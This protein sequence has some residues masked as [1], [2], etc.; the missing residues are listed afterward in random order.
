M[1]KSIQSKFQK[2]GKQEP[3]QDARVEIPTVPNPSD[4]DLVDEQPVEVKFRSEV[5]Q[6]IVGSGQ[7]VGRVRDHNEDS[8]LTLTMLTANNGEYLPIGLFIVADG[9]GG[10]KLGEVASNLAIR[11]V[12]RQILHKVM[13]SMM[14]VEPSPP[15]EGLQ[16]IVSESVLEAHHVI[17][18]KAPGSGTTFT[19]VLIVGKQMLIAHVGDSRAYAISL[20]G[21]AEIL[22]RDHSLVKRMIELGHLT[23]EEATVHPQRNVLY[24]AL[25]QGDPFS[26]DVRSSLVPDSGYLLLCSDGLWGLVPQDEMVRVILDAP[27]PEIACQKLIDAANRAGGPDNIS[28]ILVHLPPNFS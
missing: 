16:E 18:E 15:E 3:Q 1:F 24:R 17:T 27:S 2:K 5:P 4:V 6:F 11:T 26:P 7:S 10:H 25:G 14:D 21:E 19:A 23:E 20:E 22:T 28:A 9:M 13:L 8:I 12:S